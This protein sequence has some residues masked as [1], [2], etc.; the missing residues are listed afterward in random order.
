MKGSIFENHK[1][2]IIPK[3]DSILLSTVLT[4]LIVIFLADG[5]WLLITLVRSN[6][7]YFN[8]I[9]GGVSFGTAYG[10]WRLKKWATVVARFLCFF[11]ALV[12]YAVFS[13][14]AGSDLGSSPPAYDLPFSAIWPV[15]MI[16][17][18]IFIGSIYVLGK[19]KHS[20]K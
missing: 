15:I 18:V 3:T 12:P 13:P 10:L 16:P 5:L 2:F 7:I 17:V 20:F 8:L 4:F 19:H 9:L 11:L 1:W 6:S 14:M